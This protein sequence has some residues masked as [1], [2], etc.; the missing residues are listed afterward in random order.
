MMKSDVKDDLFDKTKK[1]VK[2]ILQKIQRVILNYNNLQATKDGINI[3]I[4]G[5]PN[6]GKSTLINSISRD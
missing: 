2:V 1:E 4:L 5:K 6:V 3:T